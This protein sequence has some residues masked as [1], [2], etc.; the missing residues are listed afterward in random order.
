MNQTRPE[1]TAAGA[2][3][4]ER[5][6]Q[7]M[8]ESELAE[9]IGAFN[10]VTAKLHGAHESLRQEVGRL[11]DELRLANEQL[12]RSRRLAAL[13]EMAAGIAHEVRNPL[14][15]IGLYA[16]MLE[17]DLTDRPGERRVAEKIGAAVRGLDAVV[18]DV[19]AFAREARISPEA[20]D[21]WEVLDRAIDECLGQDGLGEV[22]PKTVHVERLGMGLSG[23]SC[24]VL[25]CD[26]GLA[27]RAIV[28][29][30]RNAV[31]AMREDRAC[32]HPRLRVE[33][34]DRATLEPDGTSG[35]Y[36]AIIVGDNGPGIPPEVIGRMFNPFFTTRATG[37][38]LGL[39]IVHRIMDAH[40]GRVEVRNAR[41]GSPDDHDRPARGAVVELM[42]PDLGAHAPGLVQVVNGAR[43]E[44]SPA[45]VC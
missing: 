42:F 26:P 36:M 7:V 9:V 28:N 15:S 20:A 6:S 10:D 2:V 18:E 40:G 22:S 33:V 4:T 43:A 38:G 31:Q 24:A 32:T 39:A 17:Q 19:L 35:R 16:R 11:K 3:A 25:L 27:Q 23:T 44:G 12:G 30:I 8:S 21:A 14:G 41:D 5:P 29:V 45:L 34:C 13:G 37:T 1:I